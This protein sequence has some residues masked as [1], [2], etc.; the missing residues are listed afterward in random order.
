M[1]QFVN[2]RVERCMGYLWQVMFGRSKKLRRLNVIGIT[3]SFGEALFGKLELQVKLD[4]QVFF[5]F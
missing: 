2:Q 5:C 4:L 1:L 3:K